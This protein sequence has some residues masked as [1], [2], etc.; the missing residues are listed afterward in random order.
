MDQRFHP[1][2]FH[3]PSNGYRGALVSPVVRGD[4]LVGFHRIFLDAEGN[5]LDKMMLGDCRGGAVRLFGSAGDAWSNEGW[6]IGIDFQILEQ[7][8]RPK[9]HMDKL[10]PLLPR[11]YS[12]IRENGSGNQGAYLAEISSAMADELLL[13]LGQPVL[14]PL[15]AS[16]DQ[17]EQASF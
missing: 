12:P 16:D 9:D 11:K 3:S 4:R 7:P 14:G 13:L 6:F 5:K 1:H 2:L 17:A 15:E 10:G 8:L